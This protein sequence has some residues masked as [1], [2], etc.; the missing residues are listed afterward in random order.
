MKTRISI[1]TEKC[2]GCGKC[3]EACPNQALQ[4]LNGKVVV[5][6]EI[7]CNENHPC[8]NVCDQH[9]IILEEKRKTYCE[10]DECF[11][12]NESELY[13]W[14]I[15]LHQIGMNDRYLNHSKLILAADCSAFA[16]NP[17]RTV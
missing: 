8:M 3:I 10:G 15:K 1:K 17:D 11:D 9:A 4:I 16:D 7:T 14:P 2:N 13:N 12:C 5:I 6:K